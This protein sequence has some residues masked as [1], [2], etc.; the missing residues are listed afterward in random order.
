MLIETSTKTYATRERA[1]KAF[2]DLYP[3]ATVKFN[4]MVAT[5]PQGRFF[6][7]CVGQRALDAGTHFHF[8]TTN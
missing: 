4:W 2:L 7:V 5:T 6:V 8:M 3:A 1:I